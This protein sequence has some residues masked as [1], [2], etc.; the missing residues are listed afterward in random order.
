MFNKFP[1]NFSYDGKQYRGEVKPLSMGVE[2]RF[3]TKF[4][5]FLNNVYCGSVQRTGRRWETDSQKCVVMMD[6][7]SDHI[8]AWFD[9]YF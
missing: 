3:P 6:Q 4:Q 2:N 8:H 7:I 1:I 5:V 9:E